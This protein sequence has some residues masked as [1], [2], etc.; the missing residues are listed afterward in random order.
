MVNKKHLKICR[1]EKA[2]KHKELEDKRDSLEYEEWFLRYVPHEKKSKKQ[3]EKVKQPN[4]QTKKQPN[5]QI[6]KQPNKQTKKQPNKQ[7]KKQ[8][9]T[10]TKKRKQASKKNKTKTKICFSSS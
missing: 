4:K 3:S 10:Q 5:K 2:H 8:P 1:A 7:P 6:K 9:K